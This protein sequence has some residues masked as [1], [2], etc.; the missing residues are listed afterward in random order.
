MK[1]TERR[2]RERRSSYLSGKK[3][4]PGLK[5]K[6]ALLDRIDNTTKGAPQSARWGVWPFEGGTVLFFTDQS[7]LKRE[8]LSMP[9]QSFMQ[10]EGNK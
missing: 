4:F 7:N 9:G 8:K 5:G 1:S 2:G 6:E 3:K 10:G